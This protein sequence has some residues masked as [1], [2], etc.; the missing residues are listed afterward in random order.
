MIFQNFLTEIG[1]K[2]QT[3]K[4]FQSYYFAEDELPEHSVSVVF[5]QFSYMQSLSYFDNSHN[6]PSHYKL[7][8]IETSVRH[9]VT[10]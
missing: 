10:Q 8:Y 4:I 3:F 9:N 7:P 6:L 2:G 5:L 1:M